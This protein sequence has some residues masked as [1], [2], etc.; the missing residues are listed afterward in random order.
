MADPLKH[1]VTNWNPE[2]YKYIGSYYL[3]SHEGALELA[4]G[5]NSEEANDIILEQLLAINAEHS[6]LT[7]DDMVRCQHCGVAHKYGMAWRH[8]PSGE[9]VTTGWICADKLLPMKSA[10]DMERKRLERKA[11][12]LRKQMKRKAEIRNFYSQNPDLQEIFENGEHHIIKDIHSA[13]QKYG[14]LSDK[15]VA[16]VRKLWKEEQ[17]KK[18]KVE[19]GEIELLEEGRQTFEGTVISRKTKETFY[20]LQHKWLVEN[21]E[22]H[23]VWCTEPKQY[24]DELYREYQEARKE[25]D[26]I[27][28]GP[29]GDRRRVSFRVTISKTDDPQFYFGK[30]PSSLEILDQPSF[31]KTS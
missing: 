2:D 21:D 1:G 31:I 24:E 8:A 20:G 28:G 4:Y 3:G 22:G 12:V 29:D 19:S 10:G 25:D 26:R 6:A 23:R 14:K 27:C 17:E 7:G 5:D 13:L 18:A 11:K 30:R 9:F 15:Q 16:F